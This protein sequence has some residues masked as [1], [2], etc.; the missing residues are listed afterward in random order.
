[1]ETSKKKILIVDDDSFL[2]DMY[3]LKFSQGNFEIHTANSAKD[4]LE[5]LQGG[6]VPDIMLLDILMPEM[7]GFEMLEN[8]NKNGLAKNAVKIILSNQGQ[9]T[10]VDRGIAL[11][12]SGY[13]VKASSTPAEVIDKVIEIVAKK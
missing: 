13:I 5:K 10:D 1:M 3:A 12:A 2:I 11:G 9:Q 4:A 7:D 6:L 8:I